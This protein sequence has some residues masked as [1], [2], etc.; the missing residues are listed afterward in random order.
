MTIRGNCD[1]CGGEL[2]YSVWRE[3][4]GYVQERPGGGANHIALRKR[5]GKA[6][7]EGCMAKR[8]AGISPRQGMME[9]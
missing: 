1:D 3:V 8:K 4:K 5:T 9:L 2:T 6:I 7:C